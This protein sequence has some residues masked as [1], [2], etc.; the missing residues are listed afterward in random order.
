MA[1]SEWESWDSSLSSAQALHG[2]GQV[3]AQVKIKA[4]ALSGK[5][6]S[7]TW[8]NIASFCLL[9]TFKYTKEHY[10]LWLHAD[11]INTEIMQIGL[12]ASPGKLLTCVKGGRGLYEREFALIWNIF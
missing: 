5:Q 3:A 8:I 4:I 11:V 7:C 1:P 12:S 10:M 2:V 9:K 6:P